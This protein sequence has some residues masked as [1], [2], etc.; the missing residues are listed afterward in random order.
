VVPGPFYYRPDPKKPIW[1]HAKPEKLV[2]RGPRHYLVV[3]TKP[4]GA[5]VEARLA[6]GS[7]HMEGFF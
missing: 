5:R 2:R 3:G 1:T 4:D 6:A 7:F